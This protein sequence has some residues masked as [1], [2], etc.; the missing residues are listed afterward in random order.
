MGV[1]VMSGSFWCNT[2]DC[3]FGPQCSSDD[4]AEDLW[5][6]V[7]HIYGDPRRIRG[8]LDIE[9]EILRG[10]EA[11]DIEGQYKIKFQPYTFSDEKVATFGPASY[12]EARDFARGYEAK[13]GT[14]IIEREK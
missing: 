9:L 1:E 4:E 7:L 14:W 8:A 2:S 12:A 5:S 3:R 10:K 13:H 11:E 6:Q